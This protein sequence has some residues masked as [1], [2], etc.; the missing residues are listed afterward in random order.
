MN[1]YDYE[2]ILPLVADQQL[3][4]RTLQVTFACPT[5][6][7]LAQAREQIDPG[8]ASVAE[9]TGHRVKRSFFHSIRGPLAAAIRSLCG[10]STLGRFAGDVG[11][12]VAYVAATPTST[13]AIPASQQRRALADA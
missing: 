12:Q 8:E 5:T 6:G 13:P 10:N 3:S 4:G 11:S 9:R 1:A 7:T 2:H